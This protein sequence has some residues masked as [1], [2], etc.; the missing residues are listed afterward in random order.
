MFKPRKPWPERFWEKVNITE[1]CWIWIGSLDTSG[2]GHINFEGRLRRATHIA[3]ILT[4]GYI[5][6]NVLMCHTCD[7]PACVN[8]SH[9]F[10]GNHQTNA[11]DMVVKGRSA[12]GNQ[13][14]SRLYPERRP[15]GI[16]HPKAKLTEGQVRE[17]R[18]LSENGETQR[19]IAKVFG[20]CKNTIQSIIENKTWRHVK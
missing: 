13:S 14:S 1:S 12:K 4:F 20:V 17:I 5:P 8:P 3:W 11:D 19:H 18:C 16:N 9:L 6:S 10:I 7:T 2:Y 15:H